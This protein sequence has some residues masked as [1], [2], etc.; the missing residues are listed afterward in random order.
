[1]RMNLFAP[2]VGLA[3]VLFLSGC[4]KIIT[5]PARPSAPN[6]LD[7]GA[8]RAYDTNDDAV[9]DFFL[10]VDA[11]GRADRIGYAADKS[12]KPTDIIRLDD[13]PAGQC[14]HLVLILDGFGFD[15][16]QRYYDEK[17]LRV[18]YPPS[19]VVAPYPTVTDPAMEDL[20]H[21]PP[22]RAF[23]AAYF[24]RP[25]NLLVGG[26]REYLAGVNEPYNEILDYRA[27]TFSDAIGYIAPWDTFLSETDTC[28]AAFQRSAA[29]GPRR[30]F[31]AYFVSSAGV[32]TA[33]GEQ[34]QR[35]CLERIERMVLQ[36][37][38]TR[39]GRV[40]ITLLSDHGHSYMPASR[41]EFEK[42]LGDRGWHVGE[43]LTG[44]KSVVPVSFGLVTVANFVTTNPPELAG[45]LIAINGVELVSYVDGDAVAVLG[46]L[47]QKAYVRCVNGA[48]RYSPDSG[49]PLKLKGVLPDFSRTYT[50]DDMLALTGQHHYPI[51]LQR[52]WRAHHALVKNPPD[53]IA[54][55]ANDRY[56][57]A[58]YFDGK[59]K[60]ASTHGGLNE[61]NSTTFA[62]ST[63]GPLPPLMRSADVHTALGK[64]LGR[65]FP[66]KPW[67]GAVTR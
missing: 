31:L 17:N 15:V 51:P 52:L 36:A 47:G 66:Q 12:A 5:F 54:S 23:E 2:L 9:Q 38:Q 6:G 22:C 29:S 25:E 65:P 55:L 61:I 3:A 4:A 35:R 39:R 50:A 60:I 11:A 43:S 1:M 58:T 33:D 53:V 20:L 46:T 21:G 37:L 42:L 30:E 56:Y 19:R 26:P 63:A 18:F 27:N 8:F 32:S 40:K 48:Y 41:I 49:D 67:P 28:M 59:I 16:V 13:I 14:P 64:L 10:F 24:S 34:G 57:G 44:R 7:S 45:D 62:M